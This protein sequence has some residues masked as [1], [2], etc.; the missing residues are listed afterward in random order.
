MRSNPVHQ[1][2][3]IFQLDNILLSYLNFLTSYGRLTDLK[4]LIGLLLVSFIWLGEKIS[5]KFLL[6]GE[7][8]VCT[9][10]VQTVLT[11]LMSKLVNFKIFSDKIS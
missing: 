11:S 2:F 1:L 5:L 4:S 9:P 8:D 3:F 7:V 6:P 10:H